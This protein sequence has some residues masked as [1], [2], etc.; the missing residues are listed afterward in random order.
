MSKIGHSDQKDK[1][2]ELVER[3]WHDSHFF[4]RLIDDPHTAF[5]EVG[6]EVSRN[7]T[8]KV[9]QDSEQLFHFILPPSPIAPKTATSVRKLANPSP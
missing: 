5:H 1:L 9:L 7:I 6:I 4:H 3:A 8:I 2:A